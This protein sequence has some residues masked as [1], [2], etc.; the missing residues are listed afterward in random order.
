MP[1]PAQRPCHVWQSHKFSWAALRTGE[2]QGVVLLF[3]MLAKELGYIIEVVQKK[4]PDCE[5][6][7]PGRSRTL[8]A[9]SSSNLNSRAAIFRDH[10][11]P[12][13]GCDTIVCWRHNWPACP[14]HIE[15]VEL[16]G[17]GQFP[18]Q[19]GQLSFSGSRS[20][21]QRCTGLHLPNYSI[22]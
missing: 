11:H 12:P 17:F 13:V 22:D 10:G 18:G 15:V 7:A 1:H 9:R 16:S 20:R 14:S 6:H 8:A 5:G 4:F 2:R 3:G 19:A 21:N